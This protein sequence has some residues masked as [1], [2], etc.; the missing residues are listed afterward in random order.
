MQLPPLQPW[1]IRVLG[2]LL[3]V[4]VAEMVLVNFVLSDPSQ[5]Y[6]LLAYTPSL[7]LS[8]LYQPVTRLLIQG[9]EL[10]RVLLDLVVLYFFLPWLIDRFTRKQ[11]L[12]GALFV[13]VG[14]A[15]SGLA[16]LGLTHLAAALEITASVR[17][18]SGAA[19]GWHPF[20]VAI[21][22]LFGLALPNANINLFFVLPIKARWVLWLTVGFV[23]LGFLAQPGVQSV[24]RFGAL[25]G[26]V[27]WYFL[28]GP[29]ANQRRYKRA[30]KRI[31][32]DVRFKVYEGGKQWGQRGPDDDVWH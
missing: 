14:C 1:L 20:M 6:L 21:V 25:L 26:I 32:R 17:W 13:V 24:D 9:N 11:L 16:W 29:G 28:L 12:T 23:V 31:E 10:F 19:M 5:V 27:A 3:M 7:D 2:T 22:A 18:M 4:W 8:L 15:L 30:G